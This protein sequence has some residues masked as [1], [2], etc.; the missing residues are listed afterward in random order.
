MQDQDNE[1]NVMLSVLAGIG[2]GVMVGA[3]A[4]LLLAPKSGVETRGELGTTLGDLGHKLT[5]LSQ[6]LQ[7]KV[8]TVVEAT[9]TEGD[10]PAPTEPA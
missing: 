8:K 1:K 6:Q 10:K 4:G 7:T 3:I 2:I 9:R 5:D